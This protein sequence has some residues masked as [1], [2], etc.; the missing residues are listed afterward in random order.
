MLMAASAA[1]LVGCM[2]VPA[3][4]APPSLR[5]AVPLGPLPAAA[6]SPPGSP[7]PESA[8]WHRYH[9]ATLDALM[10]RALASAPGL[11]GSEARI[12][13][14]QAQ[15][16]AAAAVAGARVDANASVARQRLSD[17]GLFPPQFLGFHWYDEADLG[18]TA[19]YTFDWW[20]KQRAE[21]EA[22]IDQA[23]AAE[24]E[25]AAADLALSVAV[26]QTY[27]GW[28]SD[29][30]RLALARDYVTAT[31]QRRAVV[32]ARLTADVAREDELDQVDIELAAAREQ[33]AALESSAQLRTVALAALLGVAPTELPPMTAQA[34]PVSA[35]ALPENL[36]LDLIA[37]R[38]DIA[39]AR[40]RVEAASRGVEAA[41]AGFLPDVSLKA[42]LGLSSISLPRLLEIGSADPQVGAAVH[43]P[44]FDAGALRGRYEAAQAQL[45]A[46]VATYDDAVVTAARE[47]GTEALTLDD[48][49]KRRIQR[50]EQVQLTATLRERAALREQQGL[51]DARPQLL[52]TA[53]W[54]S[55]RDTLLQLDATAVNADI[56]LI[57][58][59]G[60]GFGPTT[61]AS[62]ADISGKEP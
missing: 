56:A 62:S 40:A 6:G 14:A 29:Q 7:W 11:A 36:S 33:Q 30:A 32:Q 39:A 19:E 22:A 55:A 54:L 27:F 26:A 43:L 34:L 51:A 1:T 31:E 57:Q 60:G 47:V 48:L 61:G 10:S 8:W 4:N 12:A 25:Q 9:D 3:R 41:R 53:Q 23:R 58:A 45:A 16:H 18:L 38:S 35:T 20:G 59:L 49:A 21:V 2:S 13:A 17:N 15:V 24:A 46:A 50:A 42:L 52:A 37:R 5:T 28:Q 44:L